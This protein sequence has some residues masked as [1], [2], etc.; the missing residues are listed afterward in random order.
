VKGAPLV[1]LRLQYYYSGEISVEQIWWVFLT[2]FSVLFSTIR[3]ATV[4]LT[5]LRI[6]SS[7]DYRLVQ[8]VG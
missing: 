7:G 2:D 4:A 5:I 6:F 1:S 8:Q 3:D